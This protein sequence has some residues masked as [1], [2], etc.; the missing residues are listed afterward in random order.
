MLASQ[1]RYVVA[2]RGWMVDLR[3]DFGAISLYVS[4]WR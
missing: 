3:Y 4:G 1:I 2:V